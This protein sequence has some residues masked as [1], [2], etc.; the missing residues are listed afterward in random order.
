MSFT[1]FRAGDKVVLLIEN[2]VHCAV[3]SRAAPPQR[4]QNRRAN[5]RF[6]IARLTRATRT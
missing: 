6:D 1:V 4:F 2:A 5:Q 3:H